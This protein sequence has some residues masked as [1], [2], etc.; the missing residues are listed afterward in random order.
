MAII[1]ENGK[2]EL[3]SICGG[4]LTTYSKGKC[5]LK[6]P[7]GFF[8]LYYHKACENIETREAISE[9]I[10]KIALEKKP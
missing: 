3:C 5:E 8:C 6:T 2:L 7:W 4:P 1:N 9:Q 10:I